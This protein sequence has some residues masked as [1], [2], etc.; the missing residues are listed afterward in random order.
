MT[1]YR[2]RHITII[3]DE[4]HEGSY[5]L[6]DYETKNHQQ[7]YRSDRSITIKTAVPTQSYIFDYVVA[8]YR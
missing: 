7:R 3:F 8:F 2:I 4:Q 1:D 6:T 5:R